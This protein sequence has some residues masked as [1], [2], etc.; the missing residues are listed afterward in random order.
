MLTERVREIAQRLYDGIAEITVC[1][2]YKKENG[3]VG[4]REKVLY[5]AVPCRLSY[6]SVSAAE[7]TA[8]VSRV[9]LS[10]K[11]FLSPDYKVPPGSKIT[12]TQ[13]GKTSVFKASGIP[14]VYGSHAEIMLEDFERWA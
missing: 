6:S 8:T 5:S 12:V 13:C 14:A 9:F 1:E 10:A 2:K 4:F 3:A 11:L 7:E